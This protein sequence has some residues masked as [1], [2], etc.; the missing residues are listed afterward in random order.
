MPGKGNYHQVYLTFH[1]L[2]WNIIKHYEFWN[3]AVNSLKYPQYPQVLNGVALTQ[4]LVK[5]VE[6]KLIWILYS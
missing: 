2:P 4:V 5:S 1:S 3:F 6:D